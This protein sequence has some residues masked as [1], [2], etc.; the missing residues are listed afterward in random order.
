[1]HFQRSLKAFWTSTLTATTTGT[2]V[3]TVTG[4][5]R[6]RRG[7]TVVAARTAGRRVHHPRPARSH[8]FHLDVG[9][10][11]HF[12][13]LVFPTVVVRFNG[14]LGLQHYTLQFRCLLMMMVMVV[15][16]GVSVDSSTDI[17]T[18]TNSP[19]A[20]CTTIT[21]TT[22]WSGTTNIS[23]HA[24]VGMMMIRYVRLLVYRGNG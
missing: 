23:Y 8:Q 9:R 19:I 5:G 12:R 4:R 22:H 13:V 10:S 11:R 1:M 18:C 15:C 17:S 24:D 6:S 14:H 20:T 16:A 7:G 2:V 21:S 3:A